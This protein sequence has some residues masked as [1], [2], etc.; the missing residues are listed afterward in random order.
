[1]AG[2]L[3]RYQTALTRIE[4]SQAR[5]QAPDFGLQLGRERALQS[6]ANLQVQVDELLRGPDAGLAVAITN[7]GVPEQFA[8]HHHLTL[9]IRLDELS[10]HRFPALSGRAARSS[11]RIAPTRRN[12]QCP[13]CTA[14]A[15][16]QSSD[17]AG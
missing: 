12:R 16:A 1:M 4:R 2:P 14:S 13:A 9:Q 5:R 7:T 10:R 11:S 17:V 15:R 6:G 8:E 3:R